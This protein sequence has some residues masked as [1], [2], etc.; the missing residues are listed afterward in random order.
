MSRNL[1]ESRE[2]VIQRSGETILAVAK[3]NAQA[4]PGLVRSR[5]AGQCGCREWEQR[6][7]SWGFIILRWEAVGE[8]EQEIDTVDYSAYFQVK[9]LRLRGFK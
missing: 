3:T 2:K 6:G 7:E 4:G 1:K 9:Q 5:N 8:F